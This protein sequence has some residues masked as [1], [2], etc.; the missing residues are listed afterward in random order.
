MT[1][2]HGLHGLAQCGPDCRPR[3][4]YLWPCELTLYPELMDD[5]DDR[6]AWPVWEADE[7]PAPRGLA[8]VAALMAVLM[9]ALCVAAVAVG[10]WVL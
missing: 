5:L 6:D 7:E 8:V 4:T 1:I 10:R 9:L 3:H 2:S